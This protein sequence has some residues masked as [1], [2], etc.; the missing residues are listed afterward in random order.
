M[1]GGERGISQI[2]LHPY[3]SCYSLEATV[4]VGMTNLF[5]GSDKLAEAVFAFD[6]CFG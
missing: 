1:S 4:P 3:L 2:L 6:L 5:A